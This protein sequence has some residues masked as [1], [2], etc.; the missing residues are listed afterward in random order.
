M[1]RNVILNWQKTVLVIAVIFAIILAWLGRYEL[2]PV[3]GDGMF[4]VVYR[5]DRWSG[6][7][8]YIQRSTGDQVEIKRVP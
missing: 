2:V 6:N 5:L 1:E 7:I 4:R 3:G 8:V